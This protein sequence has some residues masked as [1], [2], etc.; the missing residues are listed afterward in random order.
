MTEITERLATG[1]I[2]RSLRCAI[3][4][5]MLSGLLFGCDRGD[6]SKP[7][8]D[9]G[10][11]ELSAET[12]APRTALTFTPDVRTLHPEISAFL[13]EVLGTWL[14]GDYEGYRRFV[15]RAHTPE[16]RERFDAIREVT[17]AITVESIEPLESPQVPSPAYRVLLS[18]ELSAEHEARR[19]EKRRQLAIVVFQEVGQWRM[20]TAPAEYQP[21]DEPPPATSSAP[22]T[23]APAYPWDEEGDY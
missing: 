22:T 13:D 16:T 21:R 7:T 14:A 23:S 19:Q 17:E 15:S 18:A 2:R 5:A 12:A 9:A 11:S 6:N 10:Q 4:V 1:M 8:D 3:S 20:A